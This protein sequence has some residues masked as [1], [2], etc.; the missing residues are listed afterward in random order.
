A[1]QRGQVGCVSGVSFILLS[2]YAAL[3]NVCPAPMECGLCPFSK[4]YLQPPQLLL[5]LLL[6]S[7][8]GQLLGLF[9][10]VLQVLHCL[11]QVLLH[12]LQVVLCPES[13][14]Q[15]DLGVLERE[16]P[17]GFI[18]ASDLSIQGAL[19]GVHNSEVISLHLVNL[20]IF[21]CYFSVDLRLHL[22]ELKLQAQDLPLFMFQGGLKNV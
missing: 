3:F 7:L 8:Q 10:T 22:V 5:D 1:K 14:I 13:L 21:L 20:L 18:P 15:M 11:V 9:Q 12:P 4:Q 17:L 2:W 19:H 16:I 6:P